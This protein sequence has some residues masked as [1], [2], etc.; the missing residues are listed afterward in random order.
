MFKSCIA[1][2]TK[3]LVPVCKTL[4]A[5]GIVEMEAASFPEAQRKVQTDIDEHGFESHAAEAD[6][7]ADWLHASNLSLCD[8]EFPN[9]ENH[10]QES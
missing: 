2:M 9:R 4:R 8:H 10:S 1:I 3:F 5:Y 6:F 7:T